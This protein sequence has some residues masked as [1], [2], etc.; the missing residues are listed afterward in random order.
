MVKRLIAMPAYNEGRVIADVVKRIKAQ[1]YPNI[2]VVD[3][4]SSDNTA[5]V[6]KKAGAIV[7]THIVN[8]G[9]GAATMTAIEYAKDNGF[10]ELVL[11]DSD[12]QHD[13][14]DIKNLL[15]GKGDVV[16]GHRDWKSKNIPL[17]RKFFNKVGNVITWIFFG[18]YVK[19]SQSGFKLL[20]R[21]AIEKI[22]LT[23]DR[24]EFCSELIGEIKK[25]KL[26]YS[27]IPISVV[28]NDYSKS[29]GQNFFNGI[30][31]VMRLIFR[32]LH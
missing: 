14:K 15:K 2:L 8:R 12:G 23:Y 32:W 21:K 13:P 17:S 22:N 4:S 18:L 24:F 30:K 26:K 29:K 1:G 11:I 25:K 10:D 16:L 9:A 7:L 19:D 5:S 27:Q 6:S 28:Y 3:D 31:M 20:R